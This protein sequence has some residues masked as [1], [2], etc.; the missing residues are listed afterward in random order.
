MLST[1]SVASSSAYTSG[2]L[3]S[4]RKFLLPPFTFTFT[5]HLSLTAWH[6]H[7]SYLF[8]RIKFLDFIVSLASTLIFPPKHVLIFLYLR[9]HLL[10]TSHD[11]DVA[12]LSVRH[13]PNSCILLISGR[14]IAVT[15]I[16]RGHAY[17]TPRTG[18]T[19]IDTRPGHR[20]L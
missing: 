5:S 7:T 2:I 4:Q 10:H 8:L 20:P 19:S 9:L 3:R 1:I 15:K 12:V 18:I 6:S 16:V 14:L 17:V 11:I 13:T